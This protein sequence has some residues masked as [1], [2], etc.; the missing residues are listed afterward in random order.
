MI[1]YSLLWIC[2]LP[3]YRNH[4]KFLESDLDDLE[5]NVGPTWPKLLEPLE[6]IRDRF[7]VVWGIV[8]HLSAIKDSTE[9]RS[10][11]DEVQVLSL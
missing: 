1:N 5:R 3:F 7:S 9:L 11:I 4:V 8:N 10:A 2:I 6:K